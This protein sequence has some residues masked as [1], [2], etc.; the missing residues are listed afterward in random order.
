MSKFL[1]F[2]FLDLGSGSIEDSILSQYLSSNRIETNA[3][4]HLCSSLSRLPSWQFSN[5]CLEISH[6]NSKIYIS[7]GYF[8]LSALNLLVIL[9]KEIEIM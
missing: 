4:T 3:V 6:Q 8:S 5:V 2:G 9:K 7:P 1:F